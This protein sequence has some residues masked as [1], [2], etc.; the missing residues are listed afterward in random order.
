[1]VMATLKSRG[2]MSENKKPRMT[3]QCKAVID[4]MVKT[5]AKIMLHVADGVDHWGFSD[6]KYISQ[7]V[8]KGMHDAGMIAGQGDSFGGGRSQTYV[9][10]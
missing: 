10:V 7:S 1:M 2:R 6:G 8:A 4:H 9:L 3:K 5:G